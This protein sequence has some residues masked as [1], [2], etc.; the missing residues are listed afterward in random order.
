MLDRSA[1]LVGQTTFPPFVLR[2]G[3][4]DPASP[5][6]KLYLEFTS[7]DQAKRRF[8]GFVRQ[9]GPNGASAKW[10]FRGGWIAKWEGPRFNARGNE[11]AIESIELV[12]EGHI[13]PKQLI[14]HRVPLDDVSDAYDIFSRKQDGC[15]KPV[16]LPAGA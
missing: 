13:D 7:D 10:T 16:L 5:L 3:F 4:C 15:I 2:Q 14:T 6:Y 1:C 12:H 9:I 11:I 8:D